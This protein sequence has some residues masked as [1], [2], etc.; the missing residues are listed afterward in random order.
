MLEEGTFESFG[1]LH[2][3]K[4]FVNYLLGRFGM[5]VHTGSKRFDL[6]HKKLGMHCLNI[7][8][9]ANCWVR[10]HTGVGSSNAYRSD[11]TLR[12]EMVVDET[13]FSPHA[14]VRAIVEL[15]DRFNR[16]RP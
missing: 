7:A 10:L 11:L 1:G 8:Y 9:F 16:A 4:H 5:E 6:F 13:D 3:A 14:Q 12:V 15:E 2:P